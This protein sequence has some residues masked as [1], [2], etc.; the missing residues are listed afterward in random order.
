MPMPAKIV[1]LRDGEKL[2]GA[3]SLVRQGIAVFP[4]WWP[5]EG[6]CGCGNPACKNAGKHPLGKLV[7]RGFKDASKDETTIKRWWADYPK[8]N[9]GVVTGRVSGIV[10]VDVDGAKGQA[11]FAALLSNHD[12]ILEQ[13]NY[14][15][16]GRMDGGHHYYFQYP[17]N[18]HVPS[19]KDDGLEVKS[20]G[21]YVV[22]PPSVHESGKTYIWKN[23]EGGPLEELPRCFVDF[24][25]Q[26]SKLGS[27][28]QDAGRHA[29]TGRKR[30]VDRSPASYSPPAW[31]K[32]EED[33]IRSALEI[34]PADDRP[35]WF[36]IGAALHSTGWGD[37]AR[38]LFDEYSTK[39]EKYNST[40]QDKLWDSFARGYQG[41]PI[42]LRTLF[43]LAKSFGWKEPP[44][45]E[46]VELNER[47]FL[48]RNIGG[49]CL[50]GEM[51][52]SPLGSA[53]MLSL[54][55][56]EAFKTW[57]ANRTIVV[58]DRDGHEK[59]RP[60]GLA[61]LEHT[62]RRQYEGVD[63][64]PNAPA[65]LSNGILNL[66]RGFGVKAKRGN[67]QLMHR[68]ICQVL[69]DGDQKAAEYILCWT[70]WALQHPGELAEV[71]LVL[72]GGKG[73]GK[74][75]FGNAVT[76]CFGEHGV[77]IFQQCHLTGKFNGHLRL[78]LL[79]FADEAFWAGDKKSEGV[80]KGLITESAL[81]IEQKGI[82]PIQWPNRVKV[83]MAANAK[84]VVPAS[85]D[86][87]RFAVFDV[88]NRYAQ[89]SVPNKERE[90]YFNALH[91]EL[92]NGGVEAMLYDLLHRD[93]G[94]WH[95]RQ[96]YQTEGLRRQ[97]ERSLSPLNQWFV[98]LLQEGNLP[99]YSNGGPDIASTRLLVDD[100]KLRVPRL[101]DL[102]DQGLADFLKE[103]GCT[104]Y[105]DSQARGW[106]FPPL[107]QLRTE[108]A[109][110]YGGWEWEN[111]D[112][113]DW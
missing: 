99:W 113:L 102:S 53:K 11:K 70:A 52:P 36:E 108:W 7:P 84:W 107:A 4:L 101:R 59:G 38:A 109:R 44:P 10:V 57:Y 65:E 41:R 27:I 6:R 60:L 51:I 71:A 25:T 75:V 39:S 5:E 15:E 81:V 69:A 37:K 12:H 93:L 85:C 61:W 103:W 18:A 26:K 29:A 97:K 92:E 111:P 16:T 96:V 62:K 94:K 89:G 77:H 106:K 63:L 48:I 33:R 24:A 64:V 21:A 46:I 73:T 2:G 56:P 35:A 79:L 54:Q 104:R 100:A 32:E 8:A 90:A 74:G 42:T 22:A 31:T 58:R 40:E 14:V 30:L 34:I 72:R 66:W 43:A 91:G 87:R 86:E 50:V 80:L 1:P 9:I 95:P 98:E 105:R 78:C 68:H 17:P 112:L 110:Q 3:L 20:D 83:I 76:R 23:I 45:S 55:N 49:K 82:D 47:H 13:R 19:H 28:W 67:W 88:S